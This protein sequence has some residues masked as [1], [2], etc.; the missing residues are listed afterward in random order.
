[1]LRVVDR[2]LQD[3]EQAQRILYHGVIKHGFQYIASSRQ[4]WHT[5]YFAPESGVGLALTRHPAR[6]QGRALRIGLL[7]LGAGTL[8]TY[9]RPGDHV[10]VYEIDPDVE[11]LSRQY[12]TYFDRTDA[13]T[14]VALGDGRLTLE[15]ES[16]QGYDVL[17]LDAFSS[18][19]IPMHLLTREAFETYLRHLRPDGILA[20]N[21]SNRHVDIRPV[22]KQLA[23]HFGMR[24]LWVSNYSDDERGVYSADWGLLT[25]NEAFAEEPVVRLHLADT[26]GID[27]SLRMW[28]D[29]YTNLLSVLKWLR[30]EEE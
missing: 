23:E 18:D 17:I 2:D 9:G 8:L 30:P 4:M 20:A 13:T 11:R 14:E 21:L 24:F 3:P 22:V 6:A 5:S 12:F 27:T 19:A 7:G 10:R 16:A 1:M 26:G 25:R 29:D 15:R 28:T